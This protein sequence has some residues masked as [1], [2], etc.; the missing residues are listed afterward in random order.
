MGEHRLPFSPTLRSLALA[1][2]ALVALRLLL[3]RAV[4]ST[5]TM[6]PDRT[7][8]TGTA[9]TFAQA[10]E[11]GAPL[12]SVGSGH[13]PSLE[14]GKVRSTLSCNPVWPVTDRARR[15]TGLP[16]LQKAPCQV[17]ARLSLSLVPPE[18]R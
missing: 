10:L 13:P 16:H 18:S 8:T 9:S 2:S 15:A 3:P 4:H 7:S 6:P 17:S 1:L 12:S 11:T 5:L 14:R